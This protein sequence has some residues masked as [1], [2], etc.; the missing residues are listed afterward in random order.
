MD[1]IKSLVEKKRQSYPKNEIFDIQLNTKEKAWVKI[2]R[3]T[4]SNLFH[5][6][7]YTITANPIIVPVE[8]KSSRETLLFETSKLIRLRELSV[9]VPEILYKTDTY[10]VLEDCGSTIRDLIKKEKLKE[11]M[12]VLGEI[13]IQL[14]TLHQNK[15][16]HGG[17]QIK[18]F[19]YREGK[20]CFIDFEESFQDQVSLDD[21]QFRDLFLFLLSI[22]KESIEI[23][24]ILLINTYIEH[25]HKTDTIDRFHV[26]I[27]KVDFLI[28]IID[29]TFVG[30][31][32]DR[33][34]KSVY[35]LLKALKDIKKG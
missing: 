24:Y 11:P 15:E 20:V 30:N 7:I 27:T 33:D 29:N 32:I 26:L 16:Y 3:K 8:N 28:K 25:T 18:N 6:L 13:I 9:P 31:L 10:F 23:D 1:D 2:S 21:L 19:T 4:G 35:K 5:R 34:T 17:S 22:G 14:S 12:E